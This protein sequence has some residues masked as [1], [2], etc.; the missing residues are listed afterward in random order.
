M[1]FFSESIAV[2]KVVK[3]IVK[4]I[5]VMTGTRTDIVI[6]TGIMGHVTHD[7]HHRRKI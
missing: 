7:T 5:V 2:I 1:I 6:A 3:I 4:K